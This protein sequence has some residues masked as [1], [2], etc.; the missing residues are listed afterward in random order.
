[1][2]GPWGDGRYIDFSDESKSV[3]KKIIRFVANYLGNPDAAHVTR[4]YLSLQKEK[5]ADRM[6][7]VHCPPGE[8][9]VRRDILFLEDHRAN[10]SC[11]AS[12]E[13]IAFVERHKG[14][15]LILQY[16]HVPGNEN[17]QAEYDAEIHLLAGKLSN[18][19]P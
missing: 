15:D 10:G 17:R 2:F 12:S 5:P 14:F 7:G 9:C 3:I 6:R 18:R 1:M 16:Q 13:V 4:I 8:K 19:E 11:D